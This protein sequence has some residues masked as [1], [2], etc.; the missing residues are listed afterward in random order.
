MGC[1][2]IFT[3]IYKC[4][5]KRSKI[6]SNLTNNGIIQIINKIITSINVKDDLSEPTATKEYIFNIV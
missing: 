5:F 3:T 1:R 2:N 4:F 6:L